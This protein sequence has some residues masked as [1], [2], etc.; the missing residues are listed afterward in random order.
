MKLLG[1]PNL[2]GG[3]ILVERVREER[4]GE[5]NGDYERCFS[6]FNGTNRTPL[7]CCTDDKIR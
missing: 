6:I 7:V 1:D 2:P 3:Q 4:R 5:R